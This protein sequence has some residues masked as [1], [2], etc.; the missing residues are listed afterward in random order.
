MSN[1]AHFYEA[2][3]AIR[4]CN[5]HMLKVYLERGLSPNTERNGETL[6]MIAASYG[7]YETLSILLEAGANIDFCREFTH[8][9]AL[10]YAVLEGNLENVIFLITSG[11]NVEAISEL[12]TDPL[13]KA[14]E[15]RRFEIA[16][17]LVKNGA[18]YKM[19]EYG[20]KM[21]IP[22]DDI[23]FRTLEFFTKAGLDV[24]YQEGAD[25]LTLLNWAIIKK[26]ED[27][28][29]ELLKLGANPNLKCENG[30]NSL[31]YAVLNHA[32]DKVVRLLAKAGVDVNAADNFGNTAVHYLLETCITTNEIRV[33]NVLIEN[34]VDLKKKN[35]RAETPYQ[36]ATRRAANKTDCRA[37]WTIRS[38]YNNKK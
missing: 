32:S 35:A 21:I 27:L 28:V 8:C 19:D 16:E 33:L 3:Q 20:I 5:N 25:K 23:P 14:I 36:I 12:G 22:F 11:A 31:H 29:E 34:N 10:D 15:C 1:T 13:Y 6:L 37:L 24:N 17:W 2:R 38:Y 30:M 7:N 18:R 9:T 26:K 4:E